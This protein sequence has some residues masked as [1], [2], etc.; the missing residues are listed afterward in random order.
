MLKKNGK[1]DRDTFDTCLDR[2]AVSGAS[3]FPHCPRC[4][5]FHLYRR[6]NQ[7]NYECESCGLLEIDEARAR[8]VH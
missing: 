5:S 2:N 7:G 8:R 1:S 3:S 4:G 6:N